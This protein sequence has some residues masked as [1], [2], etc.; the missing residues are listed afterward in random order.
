[1]SFL[2]SSVSRRPR[3][4]GL[5]SSIDGEDS[6]AGGPLLSGGV[7][8]CDGYVGVGR[9]Y[10]DPLFDEILTTMDSV[11][12]FRSVPTESRLASTTQRDHLTELLT[13]DNQAHQS[14]AA[15]LLNNQLILQDSVARALQREH[16][17][18]DEVSQWVFT[19]VMTKH[20]QEVMGKLFPWMTFKTSTRASA[21]SQ[22]PV[23]SEVHK[24]MATLLHDLIPPTCSRVLEVGS[25]PAKALSFMRPGVNYRLLV[26]AKVDDIPR[27]STLARLLYTRRH[28]GHRADVITRIASDPGSVILYGELKHVRAVC[29]ALIFIHSALDNHLLDVCKAMIR[30][31]ATYT[32][33]LYTSLP[34][35]LLTGHAES[36]YTQLVASMRN[37]KVRVDGTEDTRDYRSISYYHKVMRMGESE[38]NGYLHSVK[39]VAS[40]ELC[41]PTFWFKGN[42]FCY[43]VLRRVDDSVIVRIVRNRSP[44][45]RTREIHL[46]YDVVCVTVRRY[47]KEIANGERVIERFTVS[48]SLWEAVVNF[49][50]EIN[51][52][53]EHEFQKKVTSAASYALAQ[54]STVLINGTTIQLGATVS[55][56]QLPE[57]IMYAYV[58]SV[59][60][61][62]D[63]HSD[64]VKALK[65]YG[66]VRGRMVKANK[67]LLS[68]LKW[69]LC[70]SNADLIEPNVHWLVRTF[71]CI[72]DCYV[73]RVKSLFDGVPIVQVDYAIEIPSDRSYMLSPCWEIFNRACD[74]Y[75]PLF[76]S[77]PRLYHE[78][79]GMHIVDADDQ[80]FDILSFLKK[81]PF[82]EFKDAIDRL[83]AMN[84]Q[85]ASELSRSF[86][87]VLLGL[88]SDNEPGPDDPA[89]LIRVYWPERDESWPLESYL[90][91][92]EFGTI[93]VLKIA[94]AMSIMSARVGASGLV[95]RSEVRNKRVMIVDRDKVPVDYTICYAA[96]KLYEVRDRV[97]MGLPPDITRVY[98]NPDCKFFFSLH[99]CRTLSQVVK[100]PEFTRRLM[101][102]EAVPGAGKTSLI[103]RLFTDGDY[104]MTTTRSGRKELL[105]KISVDTDDVKAR[106]LTYSSAL[107]NYD[108]TRVDRVLWADECM[109]A[110]AGC[111]EIIAALYAAKVVVA[112]GDSQQI[113]YM[114]FLGNWSV[115][116]AGYSNI[117]IRA[118][119][120]VTYRNPPEICYMM[121][122]NY[123]NGYTTVKGDRLK[124]EI[125][126]T[127]RVV[128]V[129]CGYLNDDSTA[130]AVDMMQAGKNEVART[131]AGRVNTAHEMQG[132]TLSHEVLFRFT[133][134]PFDLY[135]K[136][137]RKWNEHQLSAL[138]RVSERLTYVT[139]INDDMS[140][141]IAEAQA[142]ADVSPYVVSVATAARKTADLEA[143]ISSFV[144]RA[145]SAIDVR[146]QELR[147]LRARM[148][149]TRVTYPMSAK[150]TGVL[151]ALNVRTGERLLNLGAAP[152]HFI[153]VF[154][155]LNVD[156]THVHY[157]AGDIPLDSSNV[158]PHDSIVTLS[159]VFS[160]SPPRGYDVWI[161]DIALAGTSRADCQCSLN[162]PVVEKLIA[163]FEADSTVRRMAVKFFC[164]AVCP[165][166]RF[167]V[168]VVKPV[169]TNLA[170]AE[171]F[172]IFEK[173]ADVLS[174]VREDWVK[175]QDSALL[176]MRAVIDRDEWVKPVV[177][178]SPAVNPILSGASV[179][180]KFDKSLVVGSTSSVP[181]SS[182]AERV[183]G[184]ADDS[185]TCLSSVVRDI[186]SDLG[187]DATVPAMVSLQDLSTVEWPML[188]G[189][190]SSCPDHGDVSHSVLAIEAG[191]SI[192][193][194]CCAQAEITGGYLWVTSTS[195]QFPRALYLYGVYL[196]PEEGIA[197]V[198]N[199]EYPLG[200]FY[201][202]EFDDTNVVVVR[203]SSVDTP[204][205]LVSVTP[206]DNLLCYDAGLFRQIFETND[207]D[208]SLCPY[209]LWHLPKLSAF[210]AVCRARDI[211][212]A[213]YL[214][215]EWVGDSDAAV[216]MDYR[217]TFM[218]LN[219]HLLDARLV[220]RRVRISCGSDLDM[221]SE[222]SED[223]LREDIAESGDDSLPLSHD[224][225]EDADVAE[226][227]LP[228]HGVF[229]VADDVGRR[230]R[231]DDVA[232][233]VGRRARSDE[234]DD[235]VQEDIV[236]ADEDRPL[237]PYNVSEDVDD[238]EYLLSLRDLFGNT[239]DSSAERPRMS[240]NVLTGV[241][242]GVE[243]LLLSEDIVES[244]VECSSS[245]SDGDLTE[246]VNDVVELGL[247]CLTLAP[248]GDP[249]VEFADLLAYLRRCGYDT[250]PVI[251]N[252]C[253]LCLERTKARVLSDVLI[254]MIGLP[255]RVARRV[256][257]LE[258]LSS[259]WLAAVDCV[260]P[261]DRS[262]WY[263]VLSSGTYTDCLS[264]IMSVEF[265]CKID[266]KLSSESWYARLL[267]WLYLLPGRGC[268]N[269]GLAMLI[270]C[271]P[272][273]LWNLYTK[274]LVSKGVRDLLT[275][276]LAVLLR[277]V[278]EIMATWSDE[279][280]EQFLSDLLS[281]KSGEMC[282]VWDKWY[283]KYS[284]PEADT[285]VTISSGVESN[286][287]DDLV[288]A[289][290]SHYGIKYEPRDEP[291]DFW[292]RLATVLR[293][294]QGVLLLRPGNALRV[295]YEPGGVGHWRKVERTD[296]KPAIE[297]AAIRKYSTIIDAAN[298]NIS[299]VST[300]VRLKVFSNVSELFQYML[301]C[302]DDIHINRYE[303]NS[304]VWQATISMVARFATRGVVIPECDDVV[305]R[306]CS[307]MIFG[308]RRH[309]EVYRTLED[310]FRI[311]PDVAVSLLI[312]PYYIQLSTF[313]IERIR[314]LTAWGSVVYGPS[315]VI[316]QI[317]QAIPGF[318]GASAPS[319][320]CWCTIQ[321]TGF[322]LRTVGGSFRPLRKRLGQA[323]EKR[324]VHIP[325]AET[326]QISREFHPVIDTVLSDRSTALFLKCWEAGNVTTWGNFR[327]YSRVYPRDPVGIKHEFISENYSVHRPLAS[328]QLAYDSVLPGNRFVRTRKL[329]R[330]VEFTDL[331]FLV[332]SIKLRISK[333]SV[334][335]RK[336][337]VG[338]E[339]LM[340]TARYPKR[341]TTTKQLLLGCQKRNFACAMMAE[342]SILPLM[343][344]T[345]FEKTA[346]I[347]FRPGW[348][349][350]VRG[351]VRNPIEVTTGG[352][353]D[354]INALPPVKREGLLATDIKNWI[355]FKLNEYELSLKP[356]SKVLTSIKSQSTFQSV[357][358]I[359]AHEPYYNA[360]W[361]V[362]MREV[363][364]RFKMIARGN[365]LVN[366]GYDAADIQQFVSACKRSSSTFAGEFNS[367]EIDSSAFDKSQQETAH[368]IKL[369]FYARLGLPRHY[370]WLWD[371]SHRVTYNRSRACG[372][373]FELW[374][375]QKS[376]DAS[377]ALGNTII[378]M[379]SLAYTL[380]Y[381][382]AY[383]YALFLGDDNFLSSP[384]TSTG[385]YLH[386][387]DMRIDNFARVF[388]M[389]VKLLR[390]SHAYFCGWYIL[391]VVNEWYVVPDPV[392]RI[393]ALC[394][395]DIRDAAGLYERWQSFRDACKLYDQPAVVDSLARAISER[396]MMPV[397]ISYAIKALA[398]AAKDYRVFSRLFG[399]V[400]V[401]DY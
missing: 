306:A 143:R 44:S 178:V 293:R 227:S 210:V 106:V 399:S 177:P 215:G 93:E 117:D 291:A 125:V 77:V 355:T 114:P 390:M 361:S 222:E 108:Y 282:V 126:R 265:D 394:N 229:D 386:Y 246:S 207:T 53:L 20:S 41:P 28:S 23:A 357:Q 360:F 261:R 315:Q 218:G 254:S 122:H 264:M 241:E 21:P 113:P 187:L 18:A 118:H 259:I 14:I 342:P 202:C 256:R 212:C 340:V 275:T 195:G 353:Q 262:R 302:T 128:S 19:Q 373:S 349:D 30:T 375:Q 387:A 272:E 352:L 11:D 335:K 327:Y 351:F 389:E 271:R 173:S 296:R 305:D 68:M 220:G 348:Q 204:D 300:L 303:A 186:F 91:V 236:E 216:F 16:D 344:A 136:R 233:D 95:S 289:V 168:R 197:H 85:K 38:A 131:H 343:A 242:L 184:H 258:T 67:N 166:M 377:T 322:T 400:V 384:M 40:W 298:Y 55:A 308:H 388:N 376:G 116:C 283:A 250:T 78:A 189:V 111:I 368:S 274:I 129:V 267:P 294:A 183:V 249:D 221:I 219:L 310:D 54:A 42:A 137:L 381:G 39:N 151:S 163:D 133:D 199:A 314:M 328:L 370:V 22:H 369:Q 123:P 276:D 83:K 286:C 97:V 248:D 237:S 331:M 31:G 270:A 337:R 385:R 9:R 317:L 396:L 32:L 157:E 313:C 239:D 285:S 17:V 307:V 43:E 252:F 295:V 164:D 148:P 10:G 193:L 86:Y 161:S 230:A 110:H 158:K 8:V 228:L 299:V 76:F 224:V 89:V 66:E 26:T 231:S 330:D 174:T 46:G 273:S 138:T 59:M 366:I 1:M 329:L 301:C 191:E 172:V 27:M 288:S 320:E 60:L 339:P 75:T 154:R 13:S 105:D 180:R 101:V 48:R 395:P 374:Y 354:W 121:R 6:G 341:A 5:S 326:A 37:M 255:E 69:L 179:E 4:G 36:Q 238:E 144:A 90:S 279:D 94:A 334:R 277:S 79:T 325:L 280:L 379:A 29:D 175:C 49:W 225:S 139:P 311:N 214:S 170:N 260:L 297:M 71:R 130:H 98:V 142:L 153:P 56:T 383:D 115:V 333:L 364:A 234:T 2:C 169:G 62:S 84:N 240:V 167:S 205:T 145:G 278:T 141:G 312:V 232:D 15:C 192:R 209:E 336:N 65:D 34:A 160:T 99:I 104:A 245:I 185:V 281:D 63:V 190:V 120:T 304:P 140:A 371:I 162:M 52:S 324:S 338:L 200:H 135:N 365:V 244:G 112:L 61:M 257:V 45:F 380:P 284:A 292:F 102:I 188:F 7:P 203:Y 70:P 146:S 319:K 206:P 217:D 235:S 321:R 182:V 64:G 316:H 208:L 196:Y 266:V 100:L 149:P 356:D 213:V 80:E 25:T 147:S 96:G 132:A 88:E 87:Q 226:C 363:T 345:V 74:D 378:N 359:A 150:L 382:V 171:V 401:S 198:C 268:A 165:D 124:V 253:R 367:V 156:V 82:I 81:A 109:M 155:T 350:I 24:I 73:R 309:S 159:D 347:F 103:G 247:E 392:K 201:R 332:D 176:H 58:Y 72:R 398:S 269:I 92:V 362:L 263:N 50:T 57:L 3:A 397:N 211:P 318:S 33:A 323:K 372:V 181:D 35:V 134:R 346:A 290:V 391:P 251:N 287:V 107:I 152:G 194:P 12:L 51:G 119:M 127:P 243:C 358:V 223:S 47:R 393:E